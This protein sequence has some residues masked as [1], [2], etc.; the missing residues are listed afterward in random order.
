MLPRN[1]H[2]KRPR[3]G[4][5]F[6]CPGPALAP[7]GVV[8]AQ[9]RPAGG[10]PCHQIGVPADGDD[11]AAAPRTTHGSS[12]PAAA[13]TV[14]S[15]SAHISSAPAFVNAVS[16]SSHASQPPTMA[17]TRSNYA[18]HASTPPAQTTSNSY[19]AHGSPA[20]NVDSA[21]GSLVSHPSTPPLVANTTIANIGSDLD[22]DGLLNGPSD[23]DTDSDGMP[24]AWELRFDLDPN[25]PLESC[26]LR[27]S[28]LL[29]V[30]PPL[31]L[32]LLLNPS[33][34]LSPSSSE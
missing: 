30:R 17:I 27:L 13:T 34:L 11:A 33:L 2:R 8:A 24:D 31:L 3:R 20:P 21:F 26:G 25:D 19:I 16:Y 22:G 14:D 29:L 28:P 12:A 1:P 10:H 4:P 15:Y 6:G 7:V 5:R 23:W 9:H 18:A 32:P